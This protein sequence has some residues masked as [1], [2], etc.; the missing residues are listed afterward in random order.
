M[1]YTVIYKRQTLETV[2]CEVEA[3]DINHAL[4]LAKQGESIEKYCDHDHIIDE[5]DFKIESED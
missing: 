1:K 5:T 4:K 3:D 2:T